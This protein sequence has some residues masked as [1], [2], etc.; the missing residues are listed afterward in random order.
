MNKSKGGV[1]GR[2]RRVCVPA[3]HCVLHAYVSVDVVAVAG[4]WGWACWGA[5]LHHHRGPCWALRPGASPEGTARLEEP[6]VGQQLNKRWEGGVGLEGHLRWEAPRLNAE[7]K[8]MLDETG[9]TEENAAEG[10]KVDINIFISSHFCFKRTFFELC[11]A[12][13]VL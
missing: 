3:A 7:D 10:Y 9:R 2:T 4:G 12:F 6:L 8:Q 1:S 5:E 13:I 11:P